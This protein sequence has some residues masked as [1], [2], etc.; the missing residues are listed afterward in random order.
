ML[1]R[2]KMIKMFKKSNQSCPPTLFTG[3]TQHMEGKRLKG[4][5]DPN[6][7]QNCFYREVTARIDEEIFSGLFHHE[8]GRINAP[9]RIL[10]GMMILKDGNDWTDQQ[11]FESCDYNLLVQRA[12]GLTNY[13]DQVPCPA[14]YYNFKLS[15][16]QFE[17]D[18]Q[19]NLLDVLFQSITHDQVIRFNVS[20]QM[21]RMDSKLLHSNVAKTNRL[22]MTLGVVRKF[23]KS[24]TDSQ[25]DLL[26]EFDQQHLEKIIKK[27]PDQYTFR[28]NKKSA[29]EE[30]EKVG[31]LVYRMFVIFKELQSAE[32]NLLAR[33]WEEQFE[34]EEDSLT[35]IPTPKPKD[36]RDQGG[37]VLQSAHDPQATYRNKPGSKK[38]VITGYVCNVTETG[39][40]K[41][42]QEEQ[43]DKEETKLNLITDVQTAPATKSDD[44]FFESSID[45]SREVLSD[46]IEIVL[47]DGGYNSEANE[48]I[49]RQSNPPF[50]YYATAIQGV[51]CAY[52]FEAIE[53]N[54]YKVTDKRDGISQNAVLTATGK[55]RIKEHHAKSR[56][57]YIQPKTI[58][59]YFRRKEIEKYPPWV[60]GARANTEATIHQMF[61][62]LNGP[63]TKYRGLFKHQTYVISRAFWVNFRR[64]NDYLGKIGLNSVHFFSESLWCTI[65]LLLTIFAK[66]IILRKN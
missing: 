50:N 60:Y 17:Q 65:L 39:T 63:K 28:L 18:T 11:L 36:L 29:S 44:K 43:S 55:Y 1:L 20:G 45:R 16:M 41:Q 22:Q 37:N 32:Y 49:S 27:S 9:V 10:V 12:L 46:D 24:L 33:L 53:G 25:K 31:R 40:I 26:S 7:W 6:A 61:C 14:T 15:L 59:N 52:D 21:I 30:L 57:R 38:Q 62:N 23:Y 2:K 66:P 19:I 58:I 64:I 8:L 42:D 13:T 34:L 48:K 4:I 35:D 47:T 56:Y 5:E 51:K 3:H 54:T